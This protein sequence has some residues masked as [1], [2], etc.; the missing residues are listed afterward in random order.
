MWFIGGPD[1]VLGHVLGKGDLFSRAQGVE[2][3][4]PRLQ[5]LAIDQKKG[6]CGEV[7]SL[8]SQ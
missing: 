2:R 1:H 6:S 7:E 8:V 3:I 5:G 4:V